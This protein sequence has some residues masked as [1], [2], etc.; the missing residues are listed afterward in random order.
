MIRVLL[1]FVL[2]VLLAFGI[3]WLA[4]VIVALEGRFKKLSP[5]P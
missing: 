5:S 2:L 1:F 4:L 3:V